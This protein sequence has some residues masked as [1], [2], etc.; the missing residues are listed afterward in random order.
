MQNSW[1]QRKRRG[2]YGSRYKGVTFVKSYGKWRA[3]IVYKKKRIVI[4]Y[5]DDEA[6][7]AKAY[8]AKAREM[9]GEFAAPNFPKDPRTQEGLFQQPHCPYLFYLF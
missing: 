4:G 8:D 5:F 1:N 9:F 6:S 2:N 3:K 7:A